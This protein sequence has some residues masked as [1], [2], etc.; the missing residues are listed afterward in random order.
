MLDYKAVNVH[1]FTAL[2]VR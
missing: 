2:S 1:A